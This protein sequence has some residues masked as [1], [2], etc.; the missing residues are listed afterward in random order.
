MPQ[1]ERR[2]M[3]T[4]SNFCSSLFGFDF[5]TVAE[6]HT[7]SVGGLYLAQWC[8]R[9]GP[10]VTAVLSIVRMGLLLMVSIKDKLAACAEFVIL[11]QALFCVD[12]TNTKYY[13]LHHS[14]TLLEKT[15]KRKKKQC[16]T[17]S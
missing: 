17:Y 15:I 1:A 11:D 16:H 14:S 7:C 2:E 8:A 6:Y 12:L 9:A 3:P 13:I 4:E 10:A 5:V